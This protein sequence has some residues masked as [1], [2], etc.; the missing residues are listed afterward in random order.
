MNHS[1]DKPVI[2]PN[3]RALL[4]LCIFFALYIT[5]FIVTGDLNRLPV[6]V[7]FVL[8]S[9]VA[10]LFSGGSINLR[11]AT[12]CRGA[13]NDTIMLMVVI[14]I[15]AG[16]FAGSAKAMGAVDATVNAVLYVL[17]SGMIPA[18]IF[19]AACF[20]S[21]SMG[22]SCGTI[23]AL[24]PIAVGLSPQIGMDLP[25]M[26]GIV[27]GGSMFGDN[28]SFISD[29]TIVA[30][31]TQQV[32]MKDKFIVNVR[33]VWPMT[34]LLVLFY[35]Y[36][37]YGLHHGMHVVEDVKWIK[38]IP[39]LVVLGLALSQVNVMIVLLAGIF[40]SGVIGLF[41]AGFT[42]W[43]WAKAVNTGIV[44][45][46]GELIIVTLLAGGMFEVIRRNGGVDWLVDRI[47]KNIRSKRKAEA[48]IAALV[49]CTDIC[50]ANN[51]IAL[52]ITGPVARKIG[53]MF[54]IDPR[55]TA[56]LL[57]T[58]SCAMQGL[59]PYGA[60][61]LIAAGIAGSVKPMEIVP[62]LYYPVLTG[63]AASLAIV[64]QYPRKYAGRKI[65]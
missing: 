15:L 7:A 26:I 38:I 57:D 33:I 10:L 3:G 53:A 55:R 65:T 17:P 39:Y 9:I 37:G 18:S 49:A 58:C 63:V 23:A 44:N 30:T 27:I 19:V 34:L 12:F 40:L 59:L 51:T 42:V 32:E 1:D 14:F 56:S 25:A 21:M 16:A 22:T 48:S 43:D 45:D 47:T 5:V 54:G 20:I 41:D 8:T 31:Q 46:M 2:K 62:Y 64:F 6:S 60:Q 50:T 11:I 13:A 61:V 52:I 4:P 36:Q 28:L 29:T 35:V 24:T